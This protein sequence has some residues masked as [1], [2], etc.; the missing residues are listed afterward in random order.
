MI[1]DKAVSVWICVDLCGLLWDVWIVW[2]VW[3]VVDHGVGVY[4]DLD[5]LDLDL[6]LDFE[7]LGL[8][9]PWLSLS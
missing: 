3:I 7:D 2:I 4:L 1:S 9:S 8:C 6:D 5:F